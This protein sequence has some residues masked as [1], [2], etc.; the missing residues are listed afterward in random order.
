MLTLT[1]DD[2]DKLPRLAREAMAN[3]LVIGSGDSRLRIKRAKAA[4]MAERISRADAMLAKDNNTIPPG[5]NLRAV[6]AV[7]QGDA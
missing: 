6:L 4:V 3:S 2:Y 5:A 7:L 1:I